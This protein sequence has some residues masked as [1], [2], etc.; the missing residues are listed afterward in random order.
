MQ[1][2]VYKCI[3]FTQCSLLSFGCDV[4]VCLSSVFCGYVISSVCAHAHAV[5]VYASVF[6]YIMFMMCSAALLFTN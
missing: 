3:I 2:Y 4:C 1:F 5:L 6:I